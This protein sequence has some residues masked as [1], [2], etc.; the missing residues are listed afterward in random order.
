LVDARL[1]HVGNGIYGELWAAALVSAAFATTDAATA[2]RTA[3]AVVPPGSRLAESQRALLDLRAGGRSAVDALAWVAENLGHYNWV[4]TVN[5]AALITTGLLWG[6][7]FVDTVG[8][9][10]SGGWDTD[11]TAATVGSVYGALHGRDAIPADLVGTTHVRVRSAVRDFDRVE[12]AEL[13]R[14]T[15]AIVEASR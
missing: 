1:S 13:A 7:G 10:I 3:L 12:I 8:L 5:N 9:T 6:N 15:L 2:L 4:H 11:S 14:R